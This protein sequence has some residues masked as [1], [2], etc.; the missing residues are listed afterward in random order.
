MRYDLFRRARLLRMRVQKVQETRLQAL[1]A[2]HSPQGIGHIDAIR[3]VLLCLFKPR[4]AVVDEGGYLSGASV[5]SEAEPEEAV[6]SLRK[7]K[8][9]S[10]S[11]SLIMTITSRRTVAALQ[12]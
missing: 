7:P 5:F 6:L 12:R 8:S 9:A 11:G 3:R 10:S 2:S 4:G 1:S